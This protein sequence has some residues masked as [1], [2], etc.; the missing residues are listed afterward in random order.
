MK[1]KKNEVVPEVSGLNQL[2][3]CFEVYAAAICYFAARPHVALQI[4]EALRDYRIRVSDFAIY[5][6]FESIRSYHY[7]YMSARMFNGQDIP[8]AWSTED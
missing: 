8:T 4:E 6:R 5:Y 1:E 3:R 7:A 2:L